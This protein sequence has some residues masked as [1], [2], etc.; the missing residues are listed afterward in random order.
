MTKVEISPITVKNEEQ[1]RAFLSSVKGA[2][3]LAIGDVSQDYLDKVAERISTLGS[4]HTLELCNCALKERVSFN[5][6]TQLK[7]LRICF[8]G[9]ENTLKPLPKGLEVL[10][11][12]G[13]V[14]GRIP[15]DTL[16][17]MPDLKIRIAMDKRF[18]ISSV[19][20]TLPCVEFIQK[21]AN[22]VMFP[23]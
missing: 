22:K 10:V 20:E 8:N 11:F 18:V 5:K 1:Y 4:L 14:K 19:K 16:A 17:R 15:H 23:D 6:L 2:Q 3:L 9:S 12:D 7:R 13:P 21:A